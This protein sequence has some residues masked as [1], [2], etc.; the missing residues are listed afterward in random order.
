[1]SEYVTDVN[2]EIAKKSISC[3]S[4]IAI[5][6]PAMAKTVVGHLRNFISLQIS[7]VTTETLK[8][9]KN[10]LRRYPDFI[11]EFIPFITPKLA[12]EV[13]D[14][15]GKVALSWILGQF[16]HCIMD[17]PY[18]LEKMIEDIKELQS[19]ELS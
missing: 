15:D 10:V 12:L 14:V 3:F 11:E 19:A 13:Q 8:V 6:L 2:A 18:M 7:Y 5:R 16:G 1:L 17:A 9:M 4:T